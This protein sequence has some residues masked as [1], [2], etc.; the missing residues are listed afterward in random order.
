MPYIEVSKV[1][2]IRNQLKQELPAFK[3]SVTRE[4]YSCLNVAIISGPLD[5]GLAY[6][7]VNQ[8]YIDEHYTAEIRKVLKKVNEI[9]SKDERIICVD[10]DYGSV[11][12]YYIHISVG[13]WDKPYKLM[14]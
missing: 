9:A 12:N 2:E 3:F 6:F 13:K 8:Y 14:N 10:A 11:P 5:F 7:Q 1:A 4:H